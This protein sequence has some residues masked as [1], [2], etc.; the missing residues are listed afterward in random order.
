MVS[1]RVVT[2]KAL[3]QKEIP[4]FLYGKINVTSKGVFK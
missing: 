4:A 1:H 3:K 2:F